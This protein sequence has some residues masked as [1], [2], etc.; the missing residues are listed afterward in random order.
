VVLAPDT[1]PVV[2]SDPGRPQ[3]ARL[4]LGF[5]TRLEVG[6]DAADSYT[7]ALEMFSAAEDLGYD[8]GWIAQHQR[9]GRRDAQPPRLG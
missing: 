9:A 6:A 5:L 7:F 3:P 4:K 8:T 2:G 1:A